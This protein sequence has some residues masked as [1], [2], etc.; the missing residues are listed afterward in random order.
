VA[1]SRIGQL[2]NYS[3]MA[4]DVGVAVNTVRDWMEL[5]VATFQ[6]L[7]LRPYYGDLG[8]RQIKAP[9]LYFSDTGLVCH[10][11]GWRSAETAASG[12]MAGALFENHVVAE[13]HRS[14]AHRGFE[15]PLWYWRDKERR[16]VDI[17]IVEDGRLF[18]IEVKLTASPSRR[19]VS[20]VEALMRLGAEP[21]EAALVCL[22]AQRTALGPGV[23][24][25]PAAHLE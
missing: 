23:D 25:V 4:R 1:A 9:K 11:V 15:P 7:P 22:C 5:L 16:E 12:A 19:D 17:V 10:L 20:G 18:P 8:K 13:L 21:A 14:Y 2:T 6:V 3:D 24:A